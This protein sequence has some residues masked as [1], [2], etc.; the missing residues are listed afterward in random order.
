MI[1]QVLE[2]NP[3]PFGCQEKRYPLFELDDLM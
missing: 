1:R 3:G 2:L